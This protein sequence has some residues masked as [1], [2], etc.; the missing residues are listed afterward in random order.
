M[1]I[2]DQFEKIFIGS[3]KTR[4]IEKMSN[5]M[6][7]AGTMIFTEQDI[8]RVTYPLAKILR[9]ILVENNVTYEVFHRKH[10]EYAEKSGMTGSDAN[11]NKNNLLR[12]M[13]KPKVT[14]DHVE[15]VVCV[16]LGL[17][18]LNLE[19]TLRDCT[20]GEIKNYKLSDA[21]KIAGD[22]ENTNET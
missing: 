8:L 13:K 11:S 19:F 18:L 3:N 20:T 1:V 15:T 12:A 16:I 10:R 22:Y 17:N 14:Y 21:E 6:V 9:M 2:Q 4:D 7:R 5:R